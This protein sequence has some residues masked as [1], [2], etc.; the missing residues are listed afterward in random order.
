MPVWTFFSHSHDGNRIPP[1]SRCACAFRVFSLFTQEAAQT[2]WVVGIDDSDLGLVQRTLVSDL[3]LPT[4][5]PIRSAV[6]VYG[7]SVGDVLKGAGT[8]NPNHGFLTVHGGSSQA[9]D[10]AVI[11]V[12]LPGRVSPPK[13]NRFRFLYKGSQLGSQHSMVCRVRF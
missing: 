1:N 3:D 2:S 5:F 6:L 11:L 8:G 9:T 7:R 10:V 4:S 12:W 13:K